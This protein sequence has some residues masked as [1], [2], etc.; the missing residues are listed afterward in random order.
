MGKPAFRYVSYGKCPN[1]GNPIV[2]NVECTV[3]VCTCESAI[4]VVLKPTILFRTNSQLYKKIAKIAEM[5]GVSVEEFVGKIYETALN[6]KEFVGEF[7]KQVRGGS[8]L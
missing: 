8:K 4:E 7:V 3:A 1:C 5:V 6:D 2:R